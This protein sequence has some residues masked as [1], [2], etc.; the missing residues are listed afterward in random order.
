ML[1]TLTHLLVL[2][3]SAGA[4]TPAKTHAAPIVVAQAAAPTA[5]EV[6]ANVQKFYASIKQ[7]TAKFRQEVTNVTFGQTTTNDGKVFIAKPGKM[8]WDYYPK[9]KDAKLAVKK[10]FISNGSYLYVVEHEN[11]QVIKKN[12]AND[13][14]PVAVSFLYGKGDLTAD[15]FNAPHAQAL[16]RR[17]LEA[18]EDP[19][20]RLP[21][22]C[23]AD[24]HD[25]E[26]LEHLDG[27]HAGDLGRQQ[28][29]STQRRRAEALEHPVAALEPGGDAERHHRGRHHGQGDDARRHE[30]DRVR[31][32]G[33]GDL[34]L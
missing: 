5:D 29:S 25:D 12:L 4:A 23:E 13:L 7:V 6:V 11:K 14:M 17:R 1:A 24:E 31:A 16:S 2:I 26:D 28:P 33:R 10:S 22:E 34:D 3:L 19:A 27:E 9:R 21:S 30:V 8:R 15:F 20:G 32:L 18:A